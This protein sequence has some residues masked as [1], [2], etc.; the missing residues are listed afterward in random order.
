MRFKIG[1]VLAFLVAAPHVFAEAAASVKNATGKTEIK[2]E[3]SGFLRRDNSPYQVLETLVLNEGKAL[4]IESGVTIEFVAGAGF[5]IRGGSVAV[6]GE[7][8][9]PVVFCNATGSSNWNGISLTGQH[10]ASFQNV[11]IQNATVALSV[12]NGSVE[13]KNVEIER[14]AEIGLYARAA[15][16]DVQWSSFKNNVVALWADN[17][18]YVNS[19][20]SV[21]YSNRVGVVA[22]EAS[23]LSLQGTK[24]AHNEYGLIDLERNNMRQLRSQLE[25]N[26]VGILT[27]DLPAEMMKKITVNNQKNFEQGVDRVMADLPTVPM[28]PYA[29]NFNAV[30]PTKSVDLS[31][32]RTSGKVGLAGGY[33]KVWTRHNHSGEDYVVESDTVEDGERY[34]NYFQVPGFFGELD[35]SMAMEDDEGHSLEFAANLLTDNWNRFNPENVSA[36]YTD[37]MQRL[38]VG[39]IYLSSG[40]TYMAGVNVLGGSYDLNLFRNAANEPLF[41]ASVFGGESKQPKAYGN[42]NVDV[43]KDYI[44]DG[45]VEPQ[46]LLL[47]GKLRWNMH[48]RFNGTL[49]VIGSKSLLEDP[50]LRDGSG[51]SVNT[52]SPLVSSKTFFADGNWLFFPGDIELNGQ[53]AMGAADTANVQ[54]QRAINE[55]FVDAGLNASNFSKLRKLMANPSL[56]ETLSSAELEELFGDNTML[57]TRE[58]KDKLKVLLARAKSVKEGYIASE[59]SPEDIKSWD[60]QNYAFRGSLRWDLGNT[61]LSGYVRFVGA[62]FYSAASPDL[63]QNSREVFGNLDQKVADFWKLNLNYKIS[64]EN[65]AQG[66]AYNIFG[67]AEGEKTGIVPGADEGWLKKHEQDEER[68]LYEHDAN[69]VNTFKIGKAMEVKLGYNLNYRL[70]SS[71]L[72]LYADYSAASGIYDD[73]WFSPRK[74]EDVEPV[75]NGEDT[76]WVDKG[77]WEQ[78]YGLKGHEYLATQFE[79]RLMKHTVDLELKFI[80]PKNILKIGGAWTFRNDLSRFMQDDLLDGFGF[81]DETYEIL[82]YYFHGGDYFEQRYPISLTT[83]FGGF[84]NMLAVSPRY[85]I[86][87]RDDMTDFEWVAN[88]SMTIPLSKDFLELVLTGGFRQ[89][90]LERDEEGK[91]QRESEMDVSGSGTL[92]FM[93]TDNFT[94]EWTVGSYCAYRPDSR[95]DEYKDLYGMLTL[96]YS[97]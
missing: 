72:R 3:I 46:E 21:M 11:S 1:L 78:Y 94:S 18:S 91:R 77:R 49:G 90:F 81:S 75:V 85:K 20:A 28:N 88:E 47:G 14:A 80:L 32:W 12:E 17:D 30:H 9:M 68:T 24:I 26:K 66:T 57:T 95:A 6:V 51:P 43:Y 82:G 36:I 56:V 44:E 50:L 53:V 84:R 69:L 48:R 83:N 13:L 55:V 58:M 40:E 29:E 10:R 25:L 87:N 41:V 67:L 42:R 74:G 19:D 27:N 33:H 73:D 60:G 38:A 52:A 7:P 4:V 39:D 35:V 76:I 96:N 5:D 15:L 59:D 22:G 89:E 79:E 65:A 2:G 70:H 93:H 23:I 71:N 97:F 45:E 62:D 63:L 8:Q 16:V 61:V 92:R 37:R 54:E 31:G 34:R 64:I 86:Y